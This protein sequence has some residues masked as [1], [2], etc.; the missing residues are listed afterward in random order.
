MPPGHLLS[1][2]IERISIGPGVFN[3]L[4]YSIFGVIEQSHIEP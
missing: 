3:C 4:L 1:I 2:R